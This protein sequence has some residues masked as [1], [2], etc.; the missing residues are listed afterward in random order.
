MKRF[1]SREEN[2]ETTL[3]AFPAVSLGLAF[4]W[5]WV[6]SAFFS[7]TLFGNPTLSGRA[8]MISVAA[9]SA[10]CI[11]LALFSSRSEG[12]RT[13]RFCISSSILF[14]LGTYLLVAWV[15]VPSSWIFV[16]GS[17]LTGLGSGALIVLWGY[18]FST[19]GAEK[20]TFCIISSFIGAAI[21]YFVL[22][23]LPSLLSVA[24]LSLLPVL[25]AICWVFL[26]QRE[27]DFLSGEKTIGMIDVNDTDIGKALPKECIESG[28]GSSKCAAVSS[29]AHFLS[30]GKQSSSNG[31]SESLGWRTMAGI[32]LFAFSSGFVVSVSSFGEPSAADLA[33]S[34]QILSNAAAGLVALCAI[35]FTGFHL[36]LRSTCRIVLPLVAIGFLVMSLLEDSYL[37]LGQLI[38]FFGSALFELSVW[39]TLSRASST[40]GVNPVFLFGVGH[41]GKLLGWMLGSLV[42]SVA[43]PALSHS[44]AALFV[45]V[46]LVLSTTF[47]IQEKAFGRVA[48]PSSDEESPKQ[49]TKRDEAAKVREL[50]EKY[51]LTPRETEVCELL[52]KGRTI[53]YI[54]QKLSISHSTAVTHTRHIYAKLGI[55]DRQELIDLLEH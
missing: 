17:V 40:R 41:G 46:V 15:D 36:E 6:W 28:A 21:I 30:M 52:A 34:V 53:P 7:P 27:A 39:V 25:S 35:H 44:Q 45:V 24:A 18:R 51:G 3:Q 33:G 48:V 29:W 23:G 37:M 20:S 5:A 12:I 13:N 31:L 54:E 42:V 49:T 8:Y 9:V 47:F 14:S 32:T 11:L 50:A 22:N 26:P 55:H 43:M 16:A 4:W 2:A 10:S 19:M 1:S 38:A